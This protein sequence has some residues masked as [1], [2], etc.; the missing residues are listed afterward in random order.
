LALLN[1]CA[2][3]DPAGLE[4]RFAGAPKNIIIL[5]GDGAAATQWELG[6]T[7]T[8]RFA[9]AISRSPMSS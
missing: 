4:R 7:H 9:I 8:A 3:P 5:Y 2:L 6:A 1:A